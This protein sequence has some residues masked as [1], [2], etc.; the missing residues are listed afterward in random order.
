[1]AT[2]FVVNGLL[3][4]FSVGENFGDL[5]ERR[6]EGDPASRFKI[7]FLRE[8]LAVNLEIW[9][10]TTCPQ[11]KIFENISSYRSCH[12]HSKTIGI[13][14]SV[15]G[16][17]VLM[18]DERFGLTIDCGGRSPRKQLFHFMNIANLLCPDPIPKNLIDDLCIYGRRTGSEFEGLLQC[19]R[20]CC[21]SLR[22]FLSA[23][24]TTSR[25]API[26]CRAA[27]PPR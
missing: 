20:V 21:R 18:Q 5:L 22:S 24:T 4:S 23:N 19:T 17:R 10:R 2:R 12:S 25:A 7:F 27:S 26:N 6:L 1:M 11:M 8:L 14:L 3:R 9:T 16:P 13:S 15:R